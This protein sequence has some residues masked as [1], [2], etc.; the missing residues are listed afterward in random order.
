MMVVMAVMGSGLHLIETLKEETGRC[1][2]F[3]RCEEGWDLGIASLG[4]AGAQDEG[5]R[6]SWTR[7]ALI[8]TSSLIL[9]YMPT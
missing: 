3:S 9:G 7:V 2:M 6:M 8:W 4:L 1:Q 5:V